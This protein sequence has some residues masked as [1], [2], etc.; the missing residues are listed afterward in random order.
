MSRPGRAQ[1]ASEK[2]TLNKSQ[3]W[4][5]MISCPSSQRTGSSTADSMGS[6]LMAAR[7]RGHQVEGSMRPGHW[8]I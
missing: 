5:M 4:H 1:T 6:E 2:H 8:R 3:A 7:D